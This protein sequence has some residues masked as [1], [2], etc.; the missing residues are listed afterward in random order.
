MSQS[1][2]EKF[3]ATAYQ[4][5]VDLSMQTASVF[6]RAYGKSQVIPKNRFFT[7]IL[8]LIHSQHLLHKYFPCVI[9][10]E[11]TIKEILYLRCFFNFMHIDHLAIYESAEGSNK[12]LARQYIEML[13]AMF[14]HLH[15]LGKL[16]N[17]TAKTIQQKLTQ[18]VIMSNA[19]DNGVE[20]SVVVQ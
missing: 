10:C 20:D 9:K 6:Q 15:T 3:V 11:V 2:D 18:L 5:F 7:S 17:K 14:A 13:M 19:L 8:R 12:P 1:L 4:M 16:P